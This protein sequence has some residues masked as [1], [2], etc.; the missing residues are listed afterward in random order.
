MGEMTFGRKYAIIFGGVLA[1]AGIVI[2]VVVFP[3]W[4]LIRD[5]VYEEVII[6]SNT[7]G[8]CAAH[9]GDDIPKQIS[10]C[11]AAPGDQVI[12]KYGE[13]LAWAVIVEQP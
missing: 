2:S 1:I 8:V 4:N 10:D 7:D 3:F 11:T 5:D 12:I 9:T 13:G 6:L